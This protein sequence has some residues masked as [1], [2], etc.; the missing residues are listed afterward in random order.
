MAIGTKKVTDY[1]KLTDG[2][3]YEV[4]PKTEASQV[5]GLATVATTGS[6]EDLSDK[7]EAISDDTINELS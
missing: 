3:L 4:H 5:T 2:V 1:R 7:P 6:Y